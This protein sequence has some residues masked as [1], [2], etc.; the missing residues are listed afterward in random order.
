[1]H[2]WRNALN[3]FG[4]GSSALQAGSRVYDDFSFTSYRSAMKAAVRAMISTRKPVAMAA[5]AGRHAVMITGYY[6][7]KGDPFAKDGAGRYSERVHRRGLLPER[8]AQ[9]R[10]SEERP[11]QLRQVAVQLGCDAALPTL[12]RDRQPLRRPVHARLGDVEE[13][14]VRQVGADPAGALTRA[15]R[16][17]R[18]ACSLS[19]SNGHPRLHAR[20]VACTV[21]DHRVLRLFRFRPVRKGFDGI[22]RDALIPDL[23][24]FP[25]LVDVYVGRHGPD[26]M[27][28]RLVASV[29]ES[30]AAMIDGRRRRLRSAGV[31]SRV[32]R[33]D[34]RSRSSRSTHWLET[35]RFEDA[36]DRCQ[37]GD[38]HPPAGAWAGP[39]G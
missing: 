29:W 20:G 25:D 21:S 35:F 30:R 39:P 8:P 11:D 38:R 2:G 24:A 18:D 4:W 26:E 17:A 37:A 13:R 27:G 32:P 14:V 9:E 15:G 22:L 5:W 1:M 23:F 3:F 16:G 31:P 7:L 10:R 19:G 6:D 12:P 28:E 33:R 34:D 36:L